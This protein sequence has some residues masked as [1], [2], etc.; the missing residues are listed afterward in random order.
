MSDH[1]SIRLPISHD[2]QRIRDLVAGYAARLG[3]PPDRVTDL[4]LATNEAVTNVLEHGGGSGT[5]ILTADDAQ[6]TVDITDSAGRLT[7]HHLA[8]ARIKPALAPRGFGLWLIHRLCDHVH[9]DHPRGQS[10]LRLALH[11]PTSQQ[12]RTRPRHSALADA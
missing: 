3:L 9:L 5:V 11:L 2:L 4:V 1:P 6:L 7:S 10:R 12:T 8:A